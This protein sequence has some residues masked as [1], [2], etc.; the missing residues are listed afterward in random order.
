MASHICLSQE[1][2]PQ[3]TWSTTPELWCKAG[4]LFEV[5]TIPLTFTWPGLCGLGCAHYHHLNCTDGVP[6]E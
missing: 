1:K 4:L 2:T 3:L 6:R 5:W